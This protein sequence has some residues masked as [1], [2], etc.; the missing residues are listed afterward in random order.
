MDLIWWLFLVPVVVGVIVV[1]VQ[2]HR[3]VPVSEQQRLKDAGCCLQ[4]EYDLQGNQSGVCPE[5]GAAIRR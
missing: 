4:C 3:V 5:C 2:F 1:M